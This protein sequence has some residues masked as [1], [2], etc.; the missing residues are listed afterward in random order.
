MDDGLMMKYHITKIDGS[1]VDPSGIY[2]VLKLNSRDSV[3]GLASR[4]AACAYATIIRKSLPMLAHDLEQVCKLLEQILPAKR[5]AVVD[6][7][8]TTKKPVLRYLRYA[9]GEIISRSKALALS[10]GSF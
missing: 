7:P 1:P 10:S 8:N 2:F 6:L 4:A 5:N 3:H 9:L